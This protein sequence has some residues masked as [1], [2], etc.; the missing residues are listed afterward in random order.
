MGN[1]TIGKVARQ[2]G[3]GVET[4]R[5][6]EREGLIEQ[7]PRRPSG[8]RQYPQEA[9]LRLCFIRRAKQL[10]FSLREIK[11]LLA[12]RVGGS[13]SCSEVRQRAEAKIAVVEE[14]N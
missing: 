5:F 1:L 11:E 10:G 14:K 9:V 6:Y 4:V 7:P 8:Y 12:L 2:S 3:V 13:T